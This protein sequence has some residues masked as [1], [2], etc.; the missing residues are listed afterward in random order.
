[1][2]DLPP[3]TQA[4]DVGHND[5][6]LRYEVSPGVFVDADPAAHQDDDGVDLGLIDHCLA[7]TPR[8]RVQALR[9]WARL[10]AAAKRRA[11]PDSE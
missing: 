8:Q 10:A 1:M 5:V 3:Q 2:G 11:T 6:S 4:A 7:L 9:G